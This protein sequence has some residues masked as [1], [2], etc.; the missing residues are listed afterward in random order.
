MDLEL[1]PT[2][3]MTL[4]NLDSVVLRDLDFLVEAKKGNGIPDFKQYGAKFKKPLVVG[5]GLAINTLEILFGDTA[6]VAAN[7]SNYQRVFERI[8]G[9][10]D[11]IV[12]CSA[13]GGKDSP[14]I[15]RFAASKG[16]DSV[17]LTCNPRFQAP[18][19]MT[20]YLFPSPSK[21]AQD[22]T[23]NP[24]CEQ[25]PLT[26]NCATYMGMI[27]SKTGEDPAAIKRYI[28]SFVD[29]AIKE[30]EG[31]NPLSNY[32]AFFGLVPNFLDKLAER[33]VVKCQELWGQQYGRDFCTEGDA[34]HAKT[35]VPTLRGGEVH[36]DTDGNPI[37]YNRELFMSFGVTNLIYGNE[38]DRLHIPLPNDAGYGLATAVLY[39][40]MGRLQAALPPLFK[41][42]V[43]G[44]AAEQGRMFEKTINILQDFH[45]RG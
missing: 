19:G 35:L 27:L 23:K 16:I 9:D 6:Y 10:A 25:E 2:D 11:G 36:T 15:A 5:S 38:K 45:K 43:G 1:N 44:Y 8:H 30:F 40:T 28:E 21:N 37:E 39:Y 20:A 29:P 17:I 13:S 18:V 22:K 4:P 14:I 7:E 34:R 31:K 41:L 3:T 32:R 12:V 24:D 42:S 26:Y 33:G